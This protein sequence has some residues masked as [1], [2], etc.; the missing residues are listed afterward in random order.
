MGTHIRTMPNV[1]KFIMLQDKLNLFSYLVFRRCDRST[2]DLDNK[3]I[4]LYR[5][6]IV[7]FVD[8]TITIKHFRSIKIR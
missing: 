2:H 5:P 8:Q 6:V 3:S 4:G 7:R 1:H